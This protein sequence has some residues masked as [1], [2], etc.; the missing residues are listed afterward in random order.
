MTRQDSQALWPFCT[1]TDTCVAF[2]LNQ[3]PSIKQM[4][5]DEAA[6]KYGLPDLCPALADFIHCYTPS[7]SVPYLI[8]GKHSAV[9]H[10]NIG[11]LRIQIWTGVRLQLKSFHNPDKV[12]PSKFVNAYPP[13]D[14]WLLGLYDGAIVNNDSQRLGHSAVYLVCGIL[15][16]LI[17]D[18]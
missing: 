1:F 15:L 14:D 12:M 9:A 5:V 13:C 10:P 7:N 6:K 11:S 18:L 8:G 16:V 2:Y 17:D 3:D 4:S